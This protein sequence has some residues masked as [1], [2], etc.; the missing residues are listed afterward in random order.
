MMIQ[1]WTTLRRTRQTSNCLTDCGAS[2][3]TVVKEKIKYLFLLLNGLVYLLLSVCDHLGARS[4][5]DERRESARAPS[6]APKVDVDIDMGAL[7]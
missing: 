2:L 4:H 3:K 7:S 1:P 5:S 6:K